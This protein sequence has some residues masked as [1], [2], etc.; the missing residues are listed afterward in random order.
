MLFLCATDP[1]LIVDDDRRCL[2]A[3]PAS[4]LLLRMSQDEIRAL[5]IDDLTPRELCPRLEAMW[6]ESL[7]REP[8]ARGGAAIP[9]ELQAPDGCRVPVELGFT[10]HVRPGRHLVVSRFAPAR[11]R[12][13]AEGAPAPGKELLTLR[14]REILTLVALGHTGVQIAEQL[15]LAPTT[16][17][18]HVTNALAKLKARNRA[19]GIATALRIG[20]LDL[21]PAALDGDLV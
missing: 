10:P 5:R 12:A 19:H 16:I 17:Q 15:V 8:G 13:A 18:T 9:W 3:N 2:H 7:D 20:E 4:S 11:D 21:H 6:A 1:T 14:E